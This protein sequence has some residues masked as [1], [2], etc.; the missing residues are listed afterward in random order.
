MT[1]ACRIPPDLDAKFADVLARLAEG[2]ETPLARLFA[3][4]G[5][6]PPRI[7]WDPPPDGLPDATLRNVHAVWTA[8]RR[9]RAMPDW[10]DLHAE[11]FGADLVHLAVVDPQADDDFRFVVY[12]SAVSN[13]A[14]R[15]YEGETLREM[16][17]RT[18][19]PGPIFYRAVYAMAARGRRPVFTWNAAPPWQSVTGWNRLVLPFAR[20]DGAGLRFLVGVKSEGK[21]A[22]APEAARTWRE[23]IDAA[24]ASG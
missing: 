8:L 6:L 16:G 11:A 17:Q 4:T 22:V 20:A 19:V 13:V 10:R 24:P 12:G 3:E 5:D 1:A 23:R 7:V 15:S 18:G 9:G 2:D 21:R 14:W